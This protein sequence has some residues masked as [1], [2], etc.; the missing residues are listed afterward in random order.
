MRL[1]EVIELFR[2]ICVFDATL[3]EIRIV[4]ERFRD[5]AFTGSGTNSEDITACAESDR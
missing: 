4:R 5:I 2:L 1:D 3:E